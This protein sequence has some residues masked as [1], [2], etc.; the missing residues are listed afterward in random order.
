MIT[1][2]LTTKGK[3]IQISGDLKNIALIREHFSIANPAYR[4]NVP[5][6]QPR[7]YCITPSGKFD[8]GLFGDILKYVELN[9][10]EY[11]YEDQIKK[12]YNPGFKDPEIKSL[13][14]QLRDYQESAI[15]P[16]LSQGRGV[17]LIPTAGGKTLI[18]ATLIESLR[19]N[20]N[21]PNALVLVTVPTLQ[22]V[23][24]TAND[25]LSY[26]LT[27]VTK[28]SG[29]NKPDPNATIIVAGTQIL[30]SESTDL[31]KLS[32][33]EILL[34]DEVHGLRRGNQLNKVLNF[35]ETP[36]KFGFTGTMPSTEI[37]Q[38]NIIGKI[39]PITYEQKTD[40]L[41]K[42]NFVSNFKVIILNIKH[43]ILPIVQVSS[44]TPALAYQQ[45]LEFLM[46]HERRNDIISNLANKLNQNTLIMVD[47]IDHGIQIETKLKAICGSERPVYFI[48]G[49]TE[50][51]ERE[52]IRSFMEDRSDVIIVAV[53]KI[54]STGINIPNL[55]NIIFASAGKAKIKIMQSIGRALRLHPT[56]K[57]ATI[58]DIADN[59]K[60]GKIHLSERKKLYNLEKYD[61]T[62]K[63]LS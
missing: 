63:E 23:E 53:S 50:I 18:C 14:L 59:T 1:F 51:V 35:I 40:D 21:K 47:R 26:G 36:F 30:L 8:I 6:I 15:L 25:F 27:N 38:W 54:F 42:R 55:H 7:L 32:E 9:R 48:R 33:V 56:K 10:F 28:W 34:M 41:K 44:E 37:D 19:H 39:G 57:M 16:A 31:S 60:Y 11:T 58:F 62:E 2:T 22:L 12:L 13:K 52:Q 49:A 29:N 3:Q 4:R 45:E 5:Y 24:Q 61:Y 46:Y 20:L 43:E 17:T